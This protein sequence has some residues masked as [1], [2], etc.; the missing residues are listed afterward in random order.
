MHKSIIPLSQRVDIFHTGKG[1]YHLIVVA[2]K[3]GFDKLYILQADF[4]GNMDQV[5]I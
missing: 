2:F 3:S 5:T 1:G 4:Q